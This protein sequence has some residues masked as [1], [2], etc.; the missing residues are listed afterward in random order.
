M[1]KKKHTQNKIQNTTIYMI[2][3]IIIIIQLTQIK[4]IIKL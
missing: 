3:I 2:L 4:V 1:T